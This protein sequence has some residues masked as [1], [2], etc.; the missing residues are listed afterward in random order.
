MFRVG[1]TGGI[2]SGKSTIT[3]LFK[4]Y[5]VT[6][7][8]ADKIAHAITEPNADAFAA[9]VQHFGENIVTS[10]GILDRKKLR[11]LIFQNPAERKWLENLLHPIIS[12][13]MKAESLK[14]KSPYCLLVIPL[15]AES[16]K[17][18]YLDRICAVNIPKNTTNTA[19]DATRP[20]LTNGSRSHT[21]LTM[22]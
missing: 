21:R 7:I 16:N 4:A 12:N 9:I 8:D 3:E 18:D 19:C 15:L 22:H 6:V 2:G 17:I 14:A 11:E 1:L 5:G 10:S 13:T 20:G